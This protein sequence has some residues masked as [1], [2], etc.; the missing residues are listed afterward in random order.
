MGQLGS[1]SVLRSSR[2]RRELGGEWGVF[3][4]GG[5]GGVGHSGT[6]GPLE[7]APPECVC[8]C[9]CVSASMTLRQTRRCFSYSL[10]V[11]EAVEARYSSRES[12]C[13]CECECV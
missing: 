13:E 3:L 1:D 8:W 5:G 4:G 12:V 11:P 9:V 7:G 2:C 6:Q 10:I